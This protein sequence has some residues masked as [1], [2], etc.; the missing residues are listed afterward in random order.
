[1]KKLIAMGFILALLVPVPVLADGGGRMGGGMGDS[2]SRG[3]GGGLEASGKRDKEQA[4]IR[5]Y[6]AGVELRDEALAYEGE[7][8]VST[9]TKKREKLL[10]KARKTFGKA[11]GKFEKAVQ[12]NPELYQG[13]SGFGHALRKTGD[14]ERSLEAYRNAL[15]LEPNY[16]EAI[17]YQAEAHM[18]LGQYE[19]VKTAYAKLLREKSELAARLLAEINKWL[20]QQNVAAGDAD[21]KAFAQ[22]AKDMSQPS[23]V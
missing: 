10:K 17:E 14:Y 16:H 6:N 19:K 20:P 4:A 7:A 13:W 2:G 23:G 21:L 18:H 12:Y 11:A 15:A 8:E 5:A 1:M 3:Y 9:D 22:W